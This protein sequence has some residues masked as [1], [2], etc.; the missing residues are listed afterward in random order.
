[1]KELLLSLVITGASISAIAQGQDSGAT[2]KELIT[3]SQKLLNAIPLGD[4]SIWKKYV[5]ANAIMLNWEGI[6]RS[7]AEQIK[8]M[9]PLPSRYRFVSN[10]VVNPKVV[11][12]G[13]TAI[14]S[15]L[16]DEKLETYGQFQNTPYNE[17]D[18]YIKV[19]GE[20]KLIASMFSEVVLL[21][22]PSISVSE[23]TLKSFV[24]TYQVG[25]GVSS[26]L[27][28]QKGKLV[29]EGPG[30]KARELLAETEST[31]FSRDRL[32]NRIF[33]EKNS[34]GKVASMIDRRL[35]YDLIWKKID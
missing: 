35:G 8:L 13:N 15:F 26:T 29:W 10:H 27:S 34:A 3:I 7:G 6:T 25:D 20:W 19:N 5:H 9:R 12:Y 31:F 14:I 4:S 17:T 16:A 30:I 1:M 18:T 2:A 11:E 22:P 23:A 24:G 28:L 21:P 32:R 33:F